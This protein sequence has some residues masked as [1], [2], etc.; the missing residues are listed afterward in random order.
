MIFMSL[1][2]KNQREAICMDEDS[3]LHMI[4]VRQGIMMVKMEE[5]WNAI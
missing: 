4:I 1:M 2:R 3:I 5:Y